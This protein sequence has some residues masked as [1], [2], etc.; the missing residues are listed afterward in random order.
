MKKEIAKGSKIWG[1]GISKFACEA[2][3]MVLRVLKKKS[4]Y[5]KNPNKPRLKKIPL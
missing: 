3:K 5:L 2:S 4:V 1:N